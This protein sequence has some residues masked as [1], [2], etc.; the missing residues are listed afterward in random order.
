[1]RLARSFRSSVSSDAVASGASIEAPQ[2]APF[3]EQQQ[4][5]ACLARF[6]GDRPRCLRRQ[7]TRRRGLPQPLIEA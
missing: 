6:A 4:R 5:R 3:V 1:V 2:T 7:E